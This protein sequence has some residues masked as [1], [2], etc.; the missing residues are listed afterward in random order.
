[1]ELKPN[2]TKKPWCLERKVAFES[3]TTFFSGVWTWPWSKI[4]S[5]TTKK[6]KTDEAKPNST[7]PQRN[8]CTT[9]R[10]KYLPEKRDPTSIRTEYCLALWLPLRRHGCHGEPEKYPIII[11]FGHNLHFSCWWLKYWNKC[12]GGGALDLY[13][14]TRGLAICYMYDYAA[15]SLFTFDHE[16]PQCQRLITT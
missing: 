12:I 6:L 3:N 8:V 1:M 2:S 16:V 15:S 9:I 7:S 4:F 10:Q 14:A 5:N 11:H 13:W